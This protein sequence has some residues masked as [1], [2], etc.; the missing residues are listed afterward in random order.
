[1]HKGKKSSGE[2]SG[3][4][5]QGEAGGRREGADRRMGRDE[6]R[7]TRAYAAR[8]GLRKPVR[9]AG[10]HVILGT[11]E[12]FYR[13]SSQEPQDIRGAVPGRLQHDARDESGVVR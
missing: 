13:F 11:D 8:R 10:T 1:V 12:P 3:V 6:R 2:G 7:C 5:S 4:E 9:S